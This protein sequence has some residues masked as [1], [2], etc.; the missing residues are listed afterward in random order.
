VLLVVMQRQK[1]YRLTTNKGPEGA[2]IY[3]YVKVR[4]WKRERGR[5]A[6]PF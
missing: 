3:F 1:R 6:F 2:L 4:S 5:K